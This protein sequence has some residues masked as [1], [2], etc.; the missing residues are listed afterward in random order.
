M[1]LNLVDLVSAESDG[2]KT[3][4]LNDKAT[5]NKLKKAA[6]NVNI[7]IERNSQSSNIFFSTGF[8]MATVVPLINDWKEMEGEFIDQHEV[9][10]MKILVK[11][12]ETRQENGS[13]IVEHF[14]QLLVDGQPVTIHS[15]DTRLKM[16]VQGGPILEPY[17]SRVLLPYLQDQCKIK[18]KRIKDIN[19]KVLTF[20]KPNATTRQQYKQFFVAAPS[21]LPPSPAPAALP[22]PRLPSP[23]AS[24]PVLTLAPPSP[25]ASLEPRQTTGQPKPL[26]Q[27]HLE[28]PLLQE[29]LELPLLQEQPELVILQEQPIL[30]QEQ[31][32]LHQGL[33]GIKVLTP[34]SCGEC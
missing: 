32:Q 33:V 29:Q 13:K 11:N 2:R 16:L 22:S 15:Y 17:C 26:L 30:Q 3:Y 12:V 7:K 24:P 19:K 5:A 18:A 1:A 4:F 23:L 10:G 9:D 31:V 25:P 8:Y 27:E 28:L 21:S 14:V 34:D 6:N 20:D